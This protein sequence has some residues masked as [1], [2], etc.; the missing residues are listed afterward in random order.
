M[1]KPKVEKRPPRVLSLFSGIGGLDL[2]FE[3]A[4]FEVVAMVE[5]DSDCCKTL[6]FN[7]DNFFSPNAKVIEADITKISTSEIYEG[8]IDFIIG[9]PPCQTFS[10]IGRRAGG[11]SGRLDSRGDLFEQYCRLLEHF[12]PKGFMF[13][14]VRGILST[15]KGQDWQDIL[16]AFEELGYKLS[17]RVLD[18]AG[19]GVAQHRERVILVGERNSKLFKFPRPVHGPD[20]IDQSEFVLPI[21]ALLD[22]MHTEEVDTLFNRGGKYDHLLSEIPPGMNYHHLTEEM[23][24]P[25]PKFAWRSKF[26]D[27][28]YKADPFTPVKTI[29]AS[30]GRYS[31]PFHWDS[32]RLSIGELLRLQGFP[33]G[34]ELSG[35]RTS[36]VKQIGNSVVPE[37][38]FHLAKAV[39]ATIFKDTSLQI[40]L[41]D[42]KDVLTT[43]AR[44]GN[45]ARVTR[46]NRLSN[47]ESAQLELEG[48]STSR[49]PKIMPKVLVSSATYYL[50]YP[51]ADSIQFAQKSEDNSEF[52]LDINL[53]KGLLE[54]KHRAL[55]LKFRGESAQL[56]L[57]MRS[58]TLNDVTT[59]ILDTD[60][61][62]IAKP[63]YIWDAMNVAIAAVSPYPSIHELYGHFTEPN[64][65]FKI[66]QFNLPDDKEPITRLLKWMSVDRNTFKTHPL[67]LLGEMGFNT[68]DER[69]LLEEIRDYRI[70]LRTNLT[71]NRIGIGEFRVCYPYTMPIDRKSFVTIG[72]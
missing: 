70:D 29:V 24:H 45:K 37:F 39:K 64:P 5:W 18:T 60:S 68:V 35:G 23:G 25:S 54:L 67:E 66:E 47:F 46:S 62:D 57:S 44:K 15:N 36:K 22:V 51:S 6:N 30:M 14:N 43:D 11:A 33:D 13:E 26:S 53:N 61:Y 3:R 41:L 21:N 48:F 34:Y 16:Q 19:Y 12:Q 10:A 7:K 42:E 49:D 63:F 9:G 50:K 56:R 59:I 38:A 20:S 65:R 58:K 32:R 4:G 27:F 2:G 52:S 17:Y 40:A 28:L 69:K 72:K 71:N 8:E 31:G 55:K 1:V